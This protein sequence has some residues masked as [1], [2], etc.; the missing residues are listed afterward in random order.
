MVMP[1]RL[2]RKARIRMGLYNFFTIK[3]PNYAN[4][5][6]NLF[7]PLENKTIVLH[8]PVIIN[9]IDVSF[10]FYILHDYS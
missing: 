8:F 7:L 1:G 9:A 2:E 10:S 3:I 4:V 5:K 6:D